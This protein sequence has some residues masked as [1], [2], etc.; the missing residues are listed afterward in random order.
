MKTRSL[1]NL[2]TV[3]WA[4]A[5]RPLDDQ[6]MS[7]DLH[8]VQQ[9]SF[10]FLL[11]AID[12]V[13]HG[14]EATVAARAAAEVLEQYAEESVISL[15]RRCH[16]AI[17]KTRGAVMTLAS[18]NV[19]EDTVTWLGVGNV[20]G[21]L[22]RANGKASHPRESVLLRS[23]LVGLQLP[24]LHAGVLPLAPGDLLLFATDGIYT[25][26]D[27]GIN[28]AEAPQQIADRI[29]SRWFKGTDDALVLVSRYS[30]ISHE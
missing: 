23:G 3:D 12:G 14:D 20:E 24:T 8:V 10:G 28:P 21:R 9:C 2:T 30:G 27:E 17:T 19:L 6:T 29:L 18:V 13:G 4:V 16:K 22:L 25:H 1:E 26:F 5:A 11:A 7:G 15:V